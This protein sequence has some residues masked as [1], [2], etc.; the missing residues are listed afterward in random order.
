[1]PGRIRITSGEDEGRVLDIQ[2]ELLLGRSREGD[3]RIPDREISRTHARVY[4]D[5]DGG[6]AIED[7]GST[8]GTFVGGVRITAPRPLSPGDT[9]RMGQT[10]LEVEA[11]PPPAVPLSGSDHQIG[12][13][14]RTAMPEEGEPEA[15]EPPPPPPP[16]PAAEPVAAAPLGDAVAVPPM[17]PPP[18]EAVAAPPAA[19]A[20]APKGTGVPRPLVA[21]LIGVFVLAA[22][23]IGAVVLFTGDDDD[24]G[25]PE[26]TEQ[27]A[28]DRVEGPPALVSAARA[29]GC[30]AQNNPPEGRQHVRGTPRYR[31]NPPTSGPHAPQAAA[32]GAWETS[33]PVPALVHSLEHGRVIMWHRKGDDEV[34]KE[35]RK[36]GDED[37]SKMILTPNTTGMPYRV[38]ASAWGHLL[39][40][41]ELNEEVPDAIRAFR[42]AYR[43]KG[44]EFVP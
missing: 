14:S 23:G 7:L 17:P 6:L 35:L 32:D 31:T 29:A 11:P 15:A 28:A 33:P 34:A 24:G 2:D 25:E 41:P 44:P 36:I 8:N 9:L 27:P 22:L 20:P 37:S 38:A 40:C 21:V 16:P 5:A 42:D 13:Q 18:A 26:R 39:G 3:G 43:G 1:M 4:V 12:G 19:P 30:T 10:T